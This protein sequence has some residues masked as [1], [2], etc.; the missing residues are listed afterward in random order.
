MKKWKIAIVILAIV[1]VLGYLY[2]ETSHETLE[3]ALAQDAATSS[4]SE[5]ESIIDST[6]IEDVIMCIYQTRDGRLGYSTIQYK[7][8]SYNKYTICTNENLDQT[9]L[10]PGKTMVKNYDQMGLKYTYGI[11]VQPTGNSLCYDNQSYQLHTCTYNNIKIG[12][13]LETK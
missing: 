7:D 11:V 5:P 4:L 1:G 6:T 10:Q 2:Y 13:F 3:D 8:R 9:L 12:Y